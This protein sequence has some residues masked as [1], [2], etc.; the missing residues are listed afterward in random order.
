MLLRPSAWGTERSLRH[1]LQA[2]HKGQIRS[3]VTG[4]SGA[5]GRPRGVGLPGQLSGQGVRALT[6]TSLGPTGTRQV[7]PAEQER[8]PGCACFCGQVGNRRLGDWN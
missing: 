2:H 6:G 3:L 7:R 4:R 8:G 1:W 5:A